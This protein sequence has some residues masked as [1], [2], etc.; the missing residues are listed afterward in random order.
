MSLHRFTW[1]RF[2]AVVRKEFIQM[3]RDRMTFGMMVGI[4]FLQL[5]LFGFA[6]NTDPHT[7]PTVVVAN[8]TS[9][10]AR[11]LVGAM[12]ASEY[13]DLTR[14]GPQTDAEA[15]QA[16]KRGRVQFIL[17]IPE[18]FGRDLV[19]GIRPALLLEADASDPMAIGNAVSALR[20]IMDQAWERDLQGPLDYLRRPPPPADLRVHRVF[21]PEGET[22]FNVVPGLIGVILTMTLILITALAITREKERGTMEHLLASPVRPLEVMT[23]KIV[24]Y[25]VVGYIQIVIVLL[26]A[27]FIFQVPMVGSI[28]LLLILA[29]LFMAC[30]LA[31]GITFSTIARNQ[32]QAV[33]MSFFFFLP[34]ILLSGFMFPYRGMPEWAQAVGALLP[35]THFLPIV[36]GILLKGNGLPEVLPHVWALL[37]F[38][39]V[40][41]SIG[42]KRY[43]QTLD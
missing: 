43:R 29:P 33:Q 11:S 34:S 32:L 2:A 24:P 12:R 18:H 20:G 38:L 6:I 5:I 36:R 39:A 31:V 42:L 16:L 14:P 19:Q 7:L 41:L 1:H 23:G 13:F 35:L 15:R 21:N 10:M 40:I 37:V 8:D 27:R 30:N 4:P 25:I 26:A 22:V 3:R 9:P 28:P 17:T